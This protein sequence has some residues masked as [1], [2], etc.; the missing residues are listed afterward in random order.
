MQFTAGQLRETVGISVET[1]RHWKRVLPPFSDRQGYVAA[2]SVGDIVAARVLRCLTETFGIRTGHLSSLSVDLVRLCN[3][4][5]WAKLADRD[6][7]I[8]PVG[9]TCHLARHGGESARAKP[10]II[11]P[12]SPLMIELGSE[13]QRLLP[14]S[15]QRQLQ[16]P[17]IEF[18][19]APRAARRSS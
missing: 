15:D 12:M 19:E 11:C 13:L 5:P 14:V 1:Y 3:G 16:F 18:R 10:I 4:V 17:P 2:F 7:V 8:D 6:V 9:Q